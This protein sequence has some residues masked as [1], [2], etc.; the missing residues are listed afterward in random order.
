MTSVLS[1]AELLLSKLKFHF[2][3]KKPVGF[4]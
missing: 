2:F 4:I 3:S 1:Y